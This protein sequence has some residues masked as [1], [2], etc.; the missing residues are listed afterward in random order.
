MILTVQFMLV[1]YFLYTRETAVVC[2]ANKYTV[3]V[4][5]NMFAAVLFI[6]LSMFFGSI[7]QINASENFRNLLYIPQKIIEKML[8]I[9][10]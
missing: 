8:K 6:M 1:F 3:I 2:T 10:G 7:W 5:K 4:Q 9:G